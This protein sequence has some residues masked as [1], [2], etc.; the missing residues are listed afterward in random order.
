MKTFLVLLF[1]LLLAT[2]AFVPSQAA[3]QILQRAQGF[4]SAVDTAESTVNNCYVQSV[5]AFPNRVHILCTPQVA[6]GLGPSQ[7]ALAQSGQGIG[8]FAAQSGQA[9][10]VQG[11]GP[12]QAQ[13]SQAQGVGSTSTSLASGSVR[14]FA[15]EN[16]VS[17]NAMALTVL[18]VANAAVQRNRP[19][20]IVYRTNPNQNPAGCLAS[21]CRRIV[22]VSLN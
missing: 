6:Q 14:Y 8:P 19:L 11:T 13:G 18:S 1:A 12:I 7:S 9:E 5:A 2:A 20:T 22:G 15:V 16:S 4:G 3:A 17:E 21:D 10:A